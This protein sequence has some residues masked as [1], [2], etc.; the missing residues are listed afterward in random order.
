MEYK[1]KRLIILSNEEKELMRK[2]GRLIEEIKNHMRVDSSNN[3]S[4]EICLTIFND[5]DDPVVIPYSHI[6]L[7]DNVL[8]SLYAASE[9]ISNEELDN[10]Q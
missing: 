9:I 3:I 7:T 1:T 4:P 8:Y 10:G 5:Y 2:S 6:A